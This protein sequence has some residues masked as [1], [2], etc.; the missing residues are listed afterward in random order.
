MG[1][2]PEMKDV[3][4][5]GS[6]GLEGNS[7]K[8]TQAEKMDSLHPHLQ[9]IVERIISKLKDRNYGGWQPELNYG[10]RTIEEQAVL[11]SMKPPWSTIDFSFHNTLKDGKPAAQAADIIDV[12]M[13]KT[14]DDF[15]LTGGGVPGGNAAFW[16]ALGRVAKLVFGEMMEVDPKLWGGNWR[17]FKD[18]P[19][20]QLFSNSQLSIWRKD[21]EAQLS[22]EEA[23]DLASNCETGECDIPDYDGDTSEIIINYALLKDEEFEYEGTIMLF[24]M[25]SANEMSLEDLEGVSIEL[26]GPSGEDFDNLIWE[27]ED[28]LYQIAET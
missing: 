15:Y 4:F 8:A 3:Y 27:F 20:V 6:I 5:P 25:Y 10:Y 22:S 1:L 12:R 13:K 17:K 18:W 23:A 16:E 24:D 7:W 9:P 2:P 11:K 14:E 19:H 26:G 21:T 28:I